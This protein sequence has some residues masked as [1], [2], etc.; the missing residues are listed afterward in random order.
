M[1]L[2]DELRSNTVAM[3]ALTQSIDRLISMFEALPITA[4]P[5]EGKGAAVANI[6]HKDEQ[7]DSENESKNEQITDV[8]HN[9]ESILETL[10]KSDYKKDSNDDESTQIEQK[11]THDDLKGILNEYKQK[12]GLPLARK[13]VS[14]MTDGKYKMSS[15]VPDDLVDT[16]YDGVHELIY[17]EDNDL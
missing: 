16:L 10:N 12:Y 7:K 9:D 2:E 5:T 11:R 15:E 14:K 8:I 4:T 13:L 3:D 17:G 6:A 1:S